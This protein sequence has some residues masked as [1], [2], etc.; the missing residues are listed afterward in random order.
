LVSEKVKSNEISFS[1]KGFVMVKISS[2]SNYQV[3]KIVSE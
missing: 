2:T 1:A 3:L